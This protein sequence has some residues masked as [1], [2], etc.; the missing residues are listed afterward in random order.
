MVMFVYYM[1]ILISLQR[2]FSTARFTQKSVENYSLLND[3]YAGN[4]SNGSDVEIVEVA[5]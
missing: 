3:E 5:N 1:E 2:S 4:G